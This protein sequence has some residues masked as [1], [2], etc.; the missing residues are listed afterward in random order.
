[1]PESFMIFGVLGAFVVSLLVWSFHEIKRRRKA[2][3]TQA[4]K[5]GFDF[6]AYPATPSEGKIDIFSRGHGRKALNEWRGKL[7]G[8]SFRLY[9]YH[10]TEGS[11]KNSSSYDMT[12]VQLNVKGRRIP[13]FTLSPENFFHK[14]GS[15]FGY[16]D[17]DF[18]DSPEFSKNYLLRGEAE[19]KVRAFFHRGVRDR[20]SQQKG[21][22]V[23][24]GG[25]RLLI[26]KMND[27]PKPEKIYDFLIRARAIYD[28]FDV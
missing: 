21:W 14:I 8:L 4:Q 25:E 5:Y 18:S 1:M 24:G 17:F 15:V 3:A 16:Q 11:G 10:F 6:E 28:A 27:N 12:M 26:F 2:M 22:C 20:L 9:D 19:Q 7:D 13:A 23:E